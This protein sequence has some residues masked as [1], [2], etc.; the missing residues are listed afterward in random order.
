MLSAAGLKV[1][2]YD[3][4]KTRGLRDVGPIKG[5]LCHH[6]EGPAQGN[7]P[8]LDPILNRR[9]DLRRPL[10]QLGL[11]RD[12]TYYVLAAGFCQHAVSGS[13][14]GIITGNTSFIGIEA[15]N[16]GLPGDSPWPDVQMDAYRCR[17]TAIFS[18]LN[19]AAEF[20]VGHKES[21][22]PL[23]RNDD[24]DFDMEDFRDAVA[25]HLAGTVPPLPL[26]PTRELATGGASGGP[27]CGAVP[28]ADWSGLFKTNMG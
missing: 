19:L 2:E 3:G 20:C 4:R 24:P 25:A 16:T 22:Q 18:H 10:A 17:V 15:E 11:G 7:M 23:G 14:Q 6:I 12:G 26:I 1:A 13:W 5:D 21:A 9:P 27:P 8:S 28:L